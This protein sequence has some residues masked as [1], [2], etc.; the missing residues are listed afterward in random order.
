MSEAISYSALMYALAAL[1]STG[2]GGGGTPSPGKSISKIG[3]VKSEGLIDTYRVYYTDGTTW[4][5]NVTNGQNGQTPVKGTDYWTD[6]DKQEIVTNVLDELPEISTDLPAVTEDDNGKHLVVENGKWSAKNVDFT[7][8]LL[9]ENT[10]EAK[11]IYPGIN[12]YQESPTPFMLEIDSSYKVNF[13]GKEYVLNAKEF[14]GVACIGNESLT[15]GTSDTGEEFLIGT[16]EK[17]GLFI[18]TKSSGNHHIKILEYISEEELPKLLM[19]DT[20]KHLI[21]RNGKWTKEEPVCGEVYLEL[22]NQ[23]I[24]TS[25]DG[26]GKFIFTTDCDFYIQENYVY[27]ITINQ[28]NY[29]IKSKKPENYPIPYLGNL[30]L[31]D[32]TQEDSGEDFLIIAAFDQLN[33]ATETPGSYSVK[34][35]GPKIKQLDN[36][37]IQRPIIP[38]AGESAEIFNTSYNYANG[39]YSHAEGY[40]TSANGKYSHAEGYNTQAEGD[41]SHVEGHGN[42][43]YGTYSHAEGG[44]NQ[45]YGEYSH[46]EGYNNRTNGKYSHAEGYN[47]QAVGECSHVE[48]RFNIT[49]NENKYVHIIGNGTSDNPSN[50]NTIDWNGN[51]WYKGKLYLGGQGQEDTDAWEANLPKYVTGDEGKYLKILNGKPFWTISSGEGGFSPTI[52]EKINTETEYVL[53][54]TNADGSFDTPN[55]K[56][57]F[58]TEGLIIDGGEI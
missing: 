10:I 29:E 46:A 41:Y 19:S 55:L 35:I 23:T 33:I 58:P 22:F 34:L 11:E 2:G 54:V 1:N 44:S 7:E 5:Y 47:T 3:F 57:E 49:D 30:S 12:G 6:T 42:Q 9:Y 39:A 50:A 45:V 4:D 21:A 48:G 51:V 26:Q 18:Y 37:Y 8:K 13:D 38:G 17:Q 32:K 53:T 15:G 20:G 16:N 27:V 36:K 56:G 40:Q 24:S 52:T 43:T 28:K 14:E 31:Q 25:D